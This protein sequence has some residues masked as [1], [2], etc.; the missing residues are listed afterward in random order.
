MTVESKLTMSPEAA[1]LVNVHLDSAACVVA[2]VIKTTTIKLGFPKIH[3]LLL[4]SFNVR[5]GDFRI[6]IDDLMILPE[7]FLWELYP[8]ACVLLLLGD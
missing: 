8:E 5:D 7:R 3:G 6:H 2:G 4:K 1:I